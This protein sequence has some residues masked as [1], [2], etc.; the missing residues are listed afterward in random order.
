LLGRALQGPLRETLQ[1]HSEGLVLSLGTSDLVGT[2]KD[3]FL[4]LVIVCNVLSNIINA[5]L[6][7]LAAVGDF[8]QS[9]TLFRP[10]VN[11]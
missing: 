8:A 4:S 11:H 9:V 5:R 10:N 7:F 2:I 3:L 6:S 1:R